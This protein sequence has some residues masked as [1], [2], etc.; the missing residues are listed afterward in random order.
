M[1]KEKTDLV[2][3]EVLSGVAQ[4][5][6]IH[7]PDAGNP[8]RKI[9]PAYK[10]DLMLDNEEQKAK[11]TALGLKIKPA[12]AKHPMEFVTIK[13]KVAENRKPPRLVD[14]QRNDIPPSILVG[15]GSKVNV[16]FLPWG[17]GEGEV[18]AILLEIQVVD[19]VKYVPTEGEKERKSFL[20]VV[21]GGFVVPGSS[22]VTA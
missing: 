17:Y 19:L 1:S 4:Y 7:R 21:E 20:P 2:K 22:E 12:D 9:A 5:T 6:F 14:S 11:A 3:Y 8:K 18:T 15:N 16:R 13:S 10:I